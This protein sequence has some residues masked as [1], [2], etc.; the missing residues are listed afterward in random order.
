MAR[1]PKRLKTSTSS[2]DLLVI[3]SKGEE[4]RATQQEEA[5]T[6]NRVMDHPRDELLAAYHHHHH[7]E[8]AEGEDESPFGMVPPDLLFWMFRTWDP[9]MRASTLR[10]CKRW[11]HVGSAAFDLYKTNQAF[12]YG[13]LLDTKHM[14]R[15]LAD[16]RF[17]AAYLEDLSIL[18]VMFGRISER[19][20]LTD[21][22]DRAIHTDDAWMTC[23]EASVRASNPTAVECLLLHPRSVCGVAQIDHV[24][25]LALSKQDA[26]ILHA[27]CGRYAT[28]LWP[29][30]GT[31]AMTTWCCLNA[32][33]V[34]LSELLRVPA[35]C[36]VY[37]MVL[38]LRYALVN[39][40]EPLAFAVWEKEI[41]S[42]RR[43]GSST[44]ITACSH[45]WVRLTCLLMKQGMQPADRGWKMA[46]TT[47][48]VYGHLDILRL[49]CSD[50][51]SDP[52]A[53]HNRSVRHALANQQM[54]AALYLMSD[55]RV[56]PD[57]DGNNL[58][59]NLV[60]KVI[61]CDAPVTP[62]DKAE[63]VKL[64]LDRGA[65]PNRHNHEA[66][67]RSLDRHCFPVVDVLIRCHGI[68]MTTGEFYT[69]LASIPQ[70]EEYRGTRE[71]L[72]HSARFRHNFM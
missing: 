55:V 45:N 51:R 26:A 21:L 32:Y 25:R 62:R 36:T 65:D 31:T 40:L 4:K 59:H 68:S 60:C 5:A 20:I 63:A 23:F 67:R 58:Q 37:N 2:A 30:F 28:Q 9:S 15:M 14:S 50:P 11:N 43:S 47:A 34:S 16:S 8:P 22:A 10:V 42:A 12:L 44:L 38:V 6:T 52:G 48:A 72:M 61:E 54:E 66:L 17:P 27:V 64:L 69:V 1:R 70:T 29:I 71:T 3:A 19:S 46:M 56:K 53:S 33:A 18:S 35:F 57:N 49:L 41:L 24:S 39:H 7:Q 13:V